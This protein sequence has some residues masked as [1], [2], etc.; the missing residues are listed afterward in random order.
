KGGGGQWAR[1]TRGPCARELSQ[2]LL[3]AGSLAVQRRAARGLQQLTPERLIMTIKI[4]AARARPLADNGF[5]SDVLSGLSAPQKWLA[6]KYFYDERGSQLFEAIT[7]L[8]EY[9]PTRCELAILREHKADIAD[10]FGPKTA[11]SAVG[12]G[13]HR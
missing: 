3:S 13:L 5:A 2:L 9:Y 4:N 12:T 11:L 8:K 7:E 10:V 1:H 6:P